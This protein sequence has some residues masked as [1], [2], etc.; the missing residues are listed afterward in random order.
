MKK[1]LTKK[2]KSCMISISVMITDFKKSQNKRLSKN[3][4]NKQ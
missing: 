2:K 4:S 3:I 1:L